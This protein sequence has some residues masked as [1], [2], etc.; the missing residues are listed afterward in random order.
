MKRKELK[1]CVCKL[2]DYRRNLHY[3]TFITLRKGSKMQRKSSFAMTKSI[4]NLIEKNLM[5]S[6]YTTPTTFQQISDLWGV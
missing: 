4:S 1:F 3:S 2:L 5:T 6:Y